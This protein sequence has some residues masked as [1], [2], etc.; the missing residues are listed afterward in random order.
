MKANAL[1]TMIK[2]IASPME[3]RLIRTVRTGN[4]TSK[5]K[6][7]LIMM[8]PARLAKRHICNGVSIVTRFFVTEAVMITLITNTHAQIV[9]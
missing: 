8:R 2:I 9:R 3:A 5:Q 1:I 7:S 6:L 4:Q